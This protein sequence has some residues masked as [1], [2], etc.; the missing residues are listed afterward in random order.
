MTKRLNIVGTFAALAI[1]LTTFTGSAIAGNGNGSTPPGQAKQAAP[2]AQPAAT[3]AATPPGQA[4]KAAATTVPAPAAKSPGQAKQAAKAATS[5]PGV[6][7]SNTTSHW[8]TCS[9]G[10]TSSSAT[11]TGNGTKAD[12]SKQYGN[13]KTAA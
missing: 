13:G 12:S 10:G 11:C 8:S 1:G 2:A 6:K 9:T 5:T 7:P 3:P 4:K